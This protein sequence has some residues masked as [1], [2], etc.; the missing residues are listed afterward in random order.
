MDTS[1]HDLLS[2]GD[3]A[4][5]AGVKP[6]TISG[7]RQS[8]RIPPPDD[9]SIPDRPRWNRATIDEWLATRPG[10]GKRTELRKPLRVRLDH[11]R[12]AALTTAGV[13]GG[14]WGSA[15]R[16]AGVEP[17]VQMVTVERRP[18]LADVAE[19]LGCAWG[20]QTV[21]R[22]RDC[23]ADG[24]MVQRQEAWHPL[25]LVQGT[26]LEQPEVIDTGIFAALTRIGH[27]PASVSLTGIYAGP[28]S[29]REARLFRMA[30]RFPVLVVERV[31]RDAAGRVLEF[32]RVTSAG[33]RVSYAYEDL[34]L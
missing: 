29:Q 16:A 12:G 20:A 34:P 9:D 11:F 27:Q 19:R 23:F 13:P 14:P 32:L 26:E 3:I 24:V 25:D 5:M 22:C 31:T 33:N 17:S 18:A 1:P 6:G 2:I 4:D 8:G 28:P 15:C 7:Y 30:L 10:R 21:Y